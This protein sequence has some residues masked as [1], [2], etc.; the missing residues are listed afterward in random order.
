MTTFRDG[1]A[2]GQTLMLKRSP[3]YLRVTELLGT[4]NALDQLADV[5][6]P[7][8]ALYC[9]RLAEKP[10]YMHVNTGRRPG[11]GSYP[12][13]SYEL[14]AEQPP[15]ETMKDNALWREWTNKQP[16]PEFAKK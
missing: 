1:P 9:Y 13:S 6:E 14:V 7:G 15:A 12:L 8:E 4:W 11:G 5:W 10:G 2:K 16:R 3:I